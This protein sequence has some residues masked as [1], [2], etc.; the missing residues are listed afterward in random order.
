VIFTANAESKDEVKKLLSK[1]VVS[2]L[3]V[4]RSVAQTEKWSRLGTCLSAH[5]YFLAIPPSDHLATVITPKL[6]KGNSDL[7]ISTRTQDELIVLV[8]AT[9]SPTFVDN[10]PIETRYGFRL[11]TLTQAKSQSRN[12]WMKALIQAIPESGGRLSGV[13]EAALRA[14]LFLING[15]FDESH[16]QSQSIEGQ[17]P[18]HTGDYWH[19][20]LHRREPDYG[21]S[22]YWFR[23]VGRH[24]IFVQL[25][26]SVQQHLEN[27]GQTLAEKL[28]RWSN[29]LITSSGWDP[30][31]FVDLC[32]AAERDA[33]LRE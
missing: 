29:R 6:L 17:G 8:S 13:T 22:K 9:V 33:D 10:V 31:A 7:L 24:P 11:P 23:H 20:I 27:A 26:I 28:S 5:Q 16:S 19:A 3:V 30:F 15:F 21:N 32:E 14:G 25:A 2:D 1:G 18:N 12:G 4:Y